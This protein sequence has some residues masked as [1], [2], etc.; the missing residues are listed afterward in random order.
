[1]LLFGPQTPRVVIFQVL[2]GEGPGGSEGGTVGAGVGLSCGI[3]E[4]SYV[5]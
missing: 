5:Q 1:M 3:S 4:R 2:L